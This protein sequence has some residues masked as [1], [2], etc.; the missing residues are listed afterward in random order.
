M[1]ESFKNLD[2]ILHDWEKDKN[3]NSIV[4]ALNTYEKHTLAGKR[5][6]RKDTKKLSS[7]PPSS[8]TKPSTK[9]VLVSR[10]LLLKKPNKQNGYEIGSFNKFNLSVARNS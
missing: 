3:K 6:T 10:E 5:K 8:E 9:L 4:E 1:E 7:N 2:N